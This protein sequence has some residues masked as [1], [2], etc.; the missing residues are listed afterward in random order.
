MGYPHYDLVQRAHSELV[1][2]G[3]IKRRTDQ[4]Q[5]EQDKGLLTRRAAYYAFTERDETHG[6]LEKSYG[7]NS[8]G[9]SVDIIV[10]TAGT[11]WD[12]ATDS[13]GMAQPSNGGPA[14]PDPELAERWTQ[15]TAALAQIDPDT[16][17]P[18]PGPGPAPDDEDELEEILEALDRL[19]ETQARDTAMIIARDDL[20]TQ[21]VMDELHR[22]VEEFE[23]T[24]QKVLVLWLAQNRPDQPAPPEGGEGEP[25][26]DLLLLLLKA[27]V[28][29]RPRHQAI[30]G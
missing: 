16:P 24:A 10:D 3:K 11:F 20:N 28:E 17:G 12:V 19:E 26:S 21:R 23:A 29:S 4:E 25:P 5:V 15:P 9:Y 8:M 7:N 13:S 6:L 18:G 14:G 1:A 30:G 22:I 2:E 27:F